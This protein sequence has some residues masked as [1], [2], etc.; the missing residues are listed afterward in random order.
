MAQ[1]ETDRLGEQRKFGIYYDDDYDYLQ[2]LKDVSELNDVGIIERFHISVDQVTGY[3]FCPV[4]KYEQTFCVN[5]HV[6]YD[7]FNSL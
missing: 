1:N 3:N 5:F 7:L 2:H 6:H 4:L